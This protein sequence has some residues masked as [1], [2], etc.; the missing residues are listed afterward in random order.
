MKRIAKALKM[1][2]AHLIAA[3]I[4]SAQGS[5]SGVSWSCRTMEAKMANQK[6]LNI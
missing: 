5:Y 2:V 3:L 1:S 6:I 4:I